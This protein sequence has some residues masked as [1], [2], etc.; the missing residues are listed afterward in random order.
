MLLARTKYKVVLNKLTV[1][2][3]PL[4][5]AFCWPCHLWNSPVQVGIVRTSFSNLFKTGQ[6]TFSRFLHTDFFWKF[7]CSKF[8][9]DVCVVVVL[10]VL[11]LLLL[12]VVVVVVVVVAMKMWCWAVQC[13]LRTPEEWSWGWSLMV[14][15]RIVM[16]VTNV[17]VM[18]ICAWHLIEENIVPSSVGSAHLVH[19]QEK[20]FVSAGKKIVSIFPQL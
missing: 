9:F 11:L 8:L 20:Y 19:R 12:V 1:C 5:L 2:M 17:H 14:L 13:A 4:T 10:V 6:L 3:L 7:R 18:Q 16:V 15:V